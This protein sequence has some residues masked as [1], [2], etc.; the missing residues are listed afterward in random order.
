MDCISLGSLTASAWHEGKPTEQHC[1]ST[2]LDTDKR[3]V[4]RGSGTPRLVLAHLTLLSPGAQ[5]LLVFRPARKITEE[6]RS[7]EHSSAGLGRCC[8]GHQLLSG[9]G[10]ESGAL[11]QLPVLWELEGTTAA[12]AA[13]LVL[14][15]H[16]LAQDRGCV[17]NVMCMVW[18]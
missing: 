11:W 1:G 14:H 12:P 16:L 18:G 8:N 17:N 5:P 6:H 9:Q 13:L 10:Q 15:G 2:V 3:R 4:C 7:P